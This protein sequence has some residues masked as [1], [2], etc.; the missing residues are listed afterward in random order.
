MPRK[1]EQLHRVRDFLPVVTIAE[2]G[3]AYCKQHARGR[4]GVTLVAESCTLVS[5]GSGRT[6]F[7]MLGTPDGTD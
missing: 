5:S 4:H 1:R 6:Q 7:T 3:E 2:D